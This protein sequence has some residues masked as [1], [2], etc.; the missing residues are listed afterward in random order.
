LIAAFLLDHT[1][2]IMLL[3]GLVYLSD[4][5]LT[6]A[7]ARIFRTQL[8][9][10]IVFEGSFEL[11]PTYQKDVDRLRWVSTNFL[12]RW[13]L[14]ILVIPLI[15]WLSTWFIDMR[16][17]FLFFLGALFLREIPVH[18]RH[19]RN[20]ALAYFA[21][22]GSGFHGKIVYARWFSLRLSAVEFFSFALFFAALSAV[23]GSWFFIGGA[24]ACLG[25]GLQHWFW[26][27]RMI[28]AVKQA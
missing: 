10:Q 26:S 23:W 12:W 21:R 2:L 1:G 24:G 20:L 22:G 28:A 25:I 19:F 9:E 3:W 27:R 13:A 4:Y 5:Y 6:I 14:S 17:I 11:T 7:S 15:G 18:F 8:S 16:F